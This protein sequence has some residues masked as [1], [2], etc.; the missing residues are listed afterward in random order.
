MPPIWGEAKYGG[1][2]PSKVEIPYVG[3]VIE[4]SFRIAGMLAHPGQHP[5]PEEMFEGLRVLNSWLDWLKLDRMAIYAIQRAEFPIEPGQGDYSIGHCDADLDADRPVRVDRAS[6]IFTNVNPTIEMPLEVLNEQEWQA[7]SPKGM[8]S[9][10]PTKLYY[11]SLVPNGILHFWCIPTVANLMAL[12][13]WRALEQFGALAD[14]FIAAPG[15]QLACEYNLAVQLAERYPDRQKISQTS[16]ARAVSS[17]A[18][19]KRANAP[20]LL[21]Q[22]ETAALGLDYRGRYNIYSNSYSNGPRP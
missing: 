9:S 10:V 4:T 19:V 2:L 3:D 6:F 22:C 5:A 17:L 14:R 1:N 16:I 7:L 13:L 21:M 8:T 20:S 18:A 11:E 15:Y 12:Y